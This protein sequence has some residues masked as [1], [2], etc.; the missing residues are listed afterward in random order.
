M[1][2]A[3]HHTS[4]LCHFSRAD[5]FKHVL[6]QLHKNQ[7][8][9]KLKGRLGVVA[10]RPS[11]GQRLHLAFISTSCLPHGESSCTLQEA[12][13]AA[14]AKD[15]AFVI[16][17]GPDSQ[18]KFYVEFIHDPHAVPREVG[19]KLNEGLSASRWVPSLMPNRNL[20]RTQIVGK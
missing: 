4:H 14:R 16:W 9:S 19:V 2:S 1:P 5:D 3:L 18:G 11:I 6:Q 17:A 20:K 8:F 10:I 7:A 13:K 12:A 15:Q